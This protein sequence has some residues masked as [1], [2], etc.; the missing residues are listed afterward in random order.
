MPT[1]NDILEYRC[2]HVFDVMCFYGN[3]LI[4]YFHALILGLIRDPLM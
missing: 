3:A 1:E 2:Q 4:F